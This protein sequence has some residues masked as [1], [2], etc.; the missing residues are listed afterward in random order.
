[1]PI[2]SGKSDLSDEINKILRDSPHFDLDKGGV[3]AAE[4]V[5]TK[6]GLFMR[7]GKAPNKMDLVINTNYVCPKKEGRQGCQQAIPAILCVGQTLIV[8]FP[9][10]LEPK[11]LEGLATGKDCER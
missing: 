1:M 3:W 10:M 4:H 8:H 2:W 11:K 7:Q 9:S 5:E 6:L